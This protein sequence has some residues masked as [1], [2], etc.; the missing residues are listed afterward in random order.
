MVSAN[1]RLSSG[2]Q[3]TACS[4][5]SFTTLAMASLTCCIF[6]ADSDPVSVQAVP[7]ADAS[8]VMLMLSRLSTGKYTDSLPRVRRQISGCPAGSPFTLNA[9]SGLMVTV[10]TGYHPPQPLGASRTSDLSAPPATV[11]SACH[12]LS[13][14]LPRIR[15]AAAAAAASSGGGDRRNRL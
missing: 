7:N 10:S 2:S 4:P 3:A 1:M 11:P 12:F 6:S 13:E 9:P 8:A 5:C 14:Q 15:M